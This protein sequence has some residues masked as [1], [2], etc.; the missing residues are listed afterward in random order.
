M[1]SPIHFSRIDEPGSF[2]SLLFPLVCQSVRHHHKLES[3][4]I[5]PCTANDIPAVLSWYE[6]DNSL[7]PTYAE[8]LQWKEWWKNVM[9]GVDPELKVFAIRSEKGDILG[10]IALKEV[11]DWFDD[12]PTLY[13]NGLRV[14]PHQSA[15]LSLDREYRGIG[16]ALITFAVRE[17]QRRNLA[18]ISLK[19]SFGVEE[20]YRKL[21]LVEFPTAGAKSYFTLK[22]RDQINRFLGG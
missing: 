17:S 4:P 9:E 15:G 22:G 11:I 1:A 7:Q 8:D 21:G 20:F 16:E 14:H 18:G 13:I 19:S 3:L 12:Q 5:T 10:L 6:P 2:D